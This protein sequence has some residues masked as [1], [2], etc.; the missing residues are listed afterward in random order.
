MRVRPSMRDIHVHVGYGELR[1]ALVAEGV[2]WSPDV[3]ADM[4][5]RMQGLFAN[6]MA[7]AYQYGLLEDDDDDDDLGPTPE[8][9]L[10]DPRVVFLEAEEE[11]G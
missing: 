10:I 5:S 6:T 1:C 3:A 4:V 8:K 2:S 9:E 11:D 7:E